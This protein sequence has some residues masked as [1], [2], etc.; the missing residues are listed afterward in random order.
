MSIISNKNLSQDVVFSAVNVVLLKQRDV[1]LSMSP[2]SPMVGCIAKNTIYIGPA[3][4]SIM[5]SFCL[6]FPFIISFNYLRLDDPSFFEQSNHYLYTTV[7]DMTW[8]TP[9]EVLLTMNQLHQS[10]H[11]VSRLLFLLLAHN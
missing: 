10:I 3:F 4:I 11:I 6:L 5:F 8:Q 2:M 1:N 9:G 7:F